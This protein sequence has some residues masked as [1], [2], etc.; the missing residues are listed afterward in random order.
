[1]KN[2]LIVTTDTEQ[3]QLPQEQYISFF[4]HSD[5]EAIELAQQGSFDAVVMDGQLP[6]HDLKKL[7]AVLPILQPD[8]ILLQHQAAGRLRVE[9]E[10]KAAFLQRRKE[11]V[12]K[13]MV[14][15]ATQTHPWTG[16]PAF[17]A[18]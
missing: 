11:R 9:E 12:M 8:M 5:E 10:L 3:F 2:I 18:N 17:S 6:A 4:A 16:L 7:S 13:L 14:L 15:D 1:M